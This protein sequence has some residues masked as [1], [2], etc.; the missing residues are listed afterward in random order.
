M[1]HSLKLARD[2][3]QIFSPTTN[4]IHENCLKVWKYYNDLPSPNIILMTKFNLLHVCQEIDEFS[5]N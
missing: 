2:I 5:L 4:I 3:K 1:K